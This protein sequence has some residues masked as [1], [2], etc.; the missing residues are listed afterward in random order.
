MAVA[1]PL[2]FWLGHIGRGG[3][4]A[5]NLTNIGRAV[6]TFAVL[7]LLGVAIGSAKLGPYG[8]AGLPTLIALV[9]FAL[10]PLVTNTYVGVR[11]VDRDLVEAAR[12]MG[13]SGW[14]GVPPG[15]AAARAAA[16]AHRRPARARPGLGDRDDRG[17]R[18]RPGLGRIIVS[19]FAFQDQA[20]V[21]AGA[22]LVA[23]MALV[24][25]LGDGLRPASRRPAPRRVVG[26]ASEPA[27]ARA[28]RH[29]D[30]DN[31]SSLA[32]CLSWRRVTVGAGADRCPTGHAW[33]HCPRDTEGGAR[34]HFSIA[35]PARSRSRASV[36]AVLAHGGVRR[37]RPVR[38]RR[39]RRQHAERV[40]HRGADRLRPAARSRS[41]ARPSP[42]WRSC[43]RSTLRC[44]P[45]P[46][47]PST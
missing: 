25:E 19:G 21:L 36:G 34:W 22:L 47:T 30:S 42:R 45:T 27:P 31:A 28:R 40:A 17:A 26:R 4:L 29:D 5:V 41:A 37:R 18:G 46:A 13:M 14:R 43:R 33:A 15:R 35:R 16:R 2:A 12:G 8:R 1:L 20:E 11:E 23:V 38:G 44:S 39:R 24:L 7:A 9:L 6:P 32:W 3:A 10:P